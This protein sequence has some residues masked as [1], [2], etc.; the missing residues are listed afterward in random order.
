VEAGNKTFP[1]WIKKIK[2]IG[3]QWWKGKK[4]ITAERDKM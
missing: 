3:L 4:C 1:Q 2:N